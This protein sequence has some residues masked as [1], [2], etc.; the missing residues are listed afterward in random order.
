MMQQ[1]LIPVLGNRKY[2]G[3]GEYILKPISVLGIPFECNII[4]P[5]QVI[6]D[7][8]FYDM[9]NAPTRTLLKKHYL[10]E[11]Q[12]KDG[13]IT[14]AVYAGPSFNSNNG[15]YL[16]S[17]IPSELRFDPGQVRHENILSPF[18]SQY[19]VN[20]AY[21]ELSYA[22][23]SVLLKDVADAAEAEQLEIDTNRI[24]KVSN[25][26]NYE[27]SQR[28]F[29]SR[30]YQIQ[31]TPDVN[32]I[33]GFPVVILQNTGE[34]IIAFCTG[35]TKGFNASG[36]GH[37]WINLSISYPRYYYENIGKLGNLIDPTSQNNTSLEELKL[38]IGSD[39]II[40]PSE[41]SQENLI[42]AIENLYQEFL[43]DQSFGKENVKNKYYRAT[44]ENPYT[45]I[46]SYICDLDGYMKFIGLI[47]NYVTD[48]PNEY[49]NLL[50]E[51]SSEEDALS[52]NYFKVV[53]NG[54]VVE[55]KGYSNRN[56]IKKHLE[57]I[58]SA[59]KI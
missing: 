55:Y 35:V 31:V 24:N 37:K 2:D 56:I 58:S 25:F 36:E 27:F 45:N 4:W 52:T 42:S 40:E 6:S 14:T 32:I 7:S 57:W 38:L 50:F 8:I 39:S 1:I 43:N 17:F 9:I 46:D 51:S 29:G 34:H 28:Y 19:G 23:D 10:P 15:E 48:L 20:Y 49:P 33:N 11:K 26:L 13:V 53:E 47:T 30:S 59:Q 5:D 41:N 3:L 54:Q 21:L 18:E 12:G 44:K 22:F 16:T